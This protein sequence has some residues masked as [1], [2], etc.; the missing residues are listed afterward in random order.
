MPQVGCRSGHLRGKSVCRAQVTSQILFD[1]IHKFDVDF[2]LVETNFGLIAGLLKLGS[3]M[4]QSTDGGDQVLKTSNRLGKPLSESEDRILS[5][6][7]MGISFLFH[8]KS[9]EKQAFE[10]KFSLKKP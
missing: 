8:T 6:A 9:G 5:R 4:E 1:L 10:S 2:E 7:V 3:L